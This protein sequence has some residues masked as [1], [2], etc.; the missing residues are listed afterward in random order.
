[1]PGLSHRAD[2]FVAAGYRTIQD[3]MKCDEWETWSFEQQREVEY[4][5][6]L[7]VRCSLFEAIVMHMLIHDTLSEFD[8]KIKTADTMSVRRREQWN[9][10]HEIR[11]LITHPRKNG[12]EGLKFF[13]ECVE[14]VL[15]KVNGANEWDKWLEGSSSVLLKARIPSVYERTRWR[16]LILRWVPFD[17]WVPQLI[18][19]TGHQRFVDRLKDRAADKGWKITPTQ[20]LDPEGQTVVVETEEQLFEKLGEK[21]VAPWDRTEQGPQLSRRNNTYQYKDGEIKEKPRAQRL[22]HQRPRR[23][24]YHQMLKLKQEIDAQLDKSYTFPIT[25]F[26]DGFDPTL[27]PER[28]E[29]DAANPPPNWSQTMLGGKAVAASPPEQK[30]STQFVGT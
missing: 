11:I 9:R 21:F 19:T 5:E 15:Q 20:I 29:I 4:Y 30:L 14:T 10:E 22:R 17:E 6:D 12:E 24:S 16:R 8:P 1:M 23:P 2:E 26:H 28:L 3:L 7:R 13:K 27:V 25:Y 18:E